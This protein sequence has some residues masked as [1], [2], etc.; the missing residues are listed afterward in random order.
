MIDMAHCVNVKICIE[1]IETQ[2]DLDKIL[3]MQPDYIQGYYYG[4]PCSLE[5]LKKQFISN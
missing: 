2:E 5:N 1:G 3:V 4:K